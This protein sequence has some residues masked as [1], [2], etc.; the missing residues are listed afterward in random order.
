MKTNEPK[1]FTTL[2][3]WVGMG[4]GHLIV[5]W[6][7][8]LRFICFGAFTRVLLPANQIARLSL[9]HCLA[10][11]TTHAL[12]LLIFICTDKILYIFLMYGYDIFN[13][14]PYDYTYPT[15]TLHTWYSV[16]LHREQKMIVPKKIYASF[17]INRMRE[18]LIN[19]CF[20]LHYSIWHTSFYCTPLFL[21]HLDRASPVQIGQV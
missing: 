12:N 18:Q 15:S 3:T 10:H 21:A 16:T 6:V 8:L 20:C 9:A 14:H 4:L 17:C 19:D 7:H 11:I 5:Q 13:T 2:F 1:L